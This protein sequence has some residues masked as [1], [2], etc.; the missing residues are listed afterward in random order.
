[1]RWMLCFCISRKLAR[2]I[3]LHRATSESSVAIQ[4]ARRTSSS[5]WR[6]NPLT[7]SFT[8]SGSAAAASANNWQT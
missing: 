1:V 2:P 5:G 8:S 3:I 7:P 4:E 6:R